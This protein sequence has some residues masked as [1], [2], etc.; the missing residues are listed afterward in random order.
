MEKFMLEHLGKLDGINVFNSDEMVK[1]CHFKGGMGGKFKFD[2]KI[3]PRS[4]IVID[5]WASRQKKS[6]KDFIIYHEIGHIKHHDWV[7]SL[8][9][10]GINGEDR[11]IQARI[12]HNPVIVSMEIAADKY[13]AS[14]IGTKVTVKG[15]KKLRSGLP[16]IDRFGSSGKEIQTRI[17]AIK[18][19]K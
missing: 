11:A 18:C 13:A 16:I 2:G 17:K 8:L 10:F 12:N 14:K 7:K 5:D 1:S 4:A 3:F 15:L 6:V 19:S 9:L